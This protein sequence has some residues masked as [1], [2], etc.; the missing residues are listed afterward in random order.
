MSLW[1]QTVF[2]FILL[3]F[4][5]ASWGFV[6]CL[7]VAN[8]KGVFIC[9][10]SQRNSSKKRIWNDPQDRHLP[11][12]KSGFSVSER[13]TFIFSFFLNVF[14]CIEHINLFSHPSLRKK[15]KETP[16]CSRN[17]FSDRGQNHSTAHWDISLSKRKKPVCRFVNW[18][19]NWEKKNGERHNWKER[20][21]E[22]V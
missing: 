11:S 5:F 6:A 3:I 16:L 22:S 18:I 20:W 13:A 8:K 17:L 12:L 1:R 9:W 2:D 14:T 7:F 19:I 21:S 4:F 10:G 15:K